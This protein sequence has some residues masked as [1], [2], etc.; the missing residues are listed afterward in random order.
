MSCDL[1]KQQMSKKVLGIHEGTCASKKNK[2]HVGSG[3]CHRKW[4]TT[5]IAHCSSMR[6][7]GVRSEVGTD[8]NL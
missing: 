4:C 7:I 2:D 3:A 6:E 1:K 5:E 8:L